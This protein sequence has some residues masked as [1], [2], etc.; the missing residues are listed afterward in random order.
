MLTADPDFN[1]VEVHS[2]VSDSTDSCQSGKFS[3]RSAS[4]S[5]AYIVNHRA[6]SLGSRPL[7]QIFSVPFSKLNESEVNTEIIEESLVKRLKPFKKA[8]IRNS[9]VDID[10][11]DSFARKRAD[12]FGSSAD[13]EV[14][15]AEETRI[16]DLAKEIRKDSRLHVQEERKQKNDLAEWD[17]SAAIGR[18]ASGSIASAD[19]SSNSRT[20]SFGVNGSSLIRIAAEE[21]RKNRRDKAE[22]YLVDRSRAEYMFER[23]VDTVLNLVGDYILHTAPE[24]EKSDTIYH[25]SSSVDSS[26]KSRIIGTI[27]EQNISSG[28]S[29]SQ[30]PKFSDDKNCIRAS[31]QLNN[32]A[33]NP[34]NQF[35]NS[36]SHSEFFSNPTKAFIDQSAVSSKIIQPLLLPSSNPLK[37]SADSLKLE[38]AC[39]NFQGDGSSGN[40]L[41]KNSEEVAFN[42]TADYAEFLSENLFQKKLNSV[43]F[44]VVKICQKYS[45]VENRFRVQ[46]FSGSTDIRL[47]PTVFFSGGET[48]F[49][50]G[51]SYYGA[52][53]TCRIS[54]VSST[55]SFTSDAA[56][57]DIGYL[58]NMM[59]IGHRAIFAW[60][61]LL[62]TI[63]FDC[64]GEPFNVVY[65]DPLKDGGL[66][67]EPL[68]LFISLLFFDGVS[69]IF[70]AFK[71]I[72][73]YH[74]FGV[75]R[76]SLDSN[77][78]TSWN[79][80]LD[81][82][83]CI[84][85]TDS[86]CLIL[87][88]FKYIY[89]LSV[90]ILL[91]ALFEI[92]LCIRLE[93]G[94]VPTLWIMAPLWLFLILLIIELTSR[95][96]SIHNKSSVHS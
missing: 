4:A 14:N 1:L 94:T 40:D 44:L 74:L 85:A 27:H 89:Y 17:F 3:N 19:S 90:L 63:Y 82:R 2:F 73:H 9:N 6:Y 21:V 96:V 56:K 71:I 80:P 35:E 7:H 84:I 68:V 32:N 10:Y 79:F 75:G 53:N 43:P 52:I 13:T 39:F 34:I 76:R 15:S 58:S 42:Y 30:S 83:Q 78:V 12:S 55:M 64:F 24:K 62:L 61:L 11:S 92:L 20:S 36:S 18:S 65:N 47:S 31:H 66:D 49:G 86:I 37:H 41:S 67:G 38:Y 69:L 91:K 46:R 59:G 70:I 45:I 77:I 95:L 26:S 16:P 50:Y 51:G 33:V 93:S 25:S 54:F 81:K 23:P 5:E 28:S 48:F 57:D 72:R 8:G 29:R 87:Y 88:L 60:V 22:K